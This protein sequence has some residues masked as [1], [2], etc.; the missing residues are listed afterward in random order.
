VGQKSRREKFGH[1]FSF[2]GFC[3]GNSV[4]TSDTGIVQ[5][6]KDHL[7]NLLS[8]FSKYFPEVVSD[9]FKWITDLFHADSSQNCDFSVEE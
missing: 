1:V 2:E 9:K 7:V 3:G 5:C 4:K 6:I 8:K